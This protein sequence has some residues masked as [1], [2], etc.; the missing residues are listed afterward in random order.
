LTTWT[1][2]R[3]QKSKSHL[4]KKWP[5]QREKKRT[6]KEGVETVFKKKKLFELGNEAVG[7][8]QFHFSKY[9]EKVGVLT[10]LEKKGAGKSVEGPRLGATPEPETPNTGR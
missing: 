4:G 2:N 1:Q 10:G 5:V 6:D 7:K 8:I 9:Q 3:G